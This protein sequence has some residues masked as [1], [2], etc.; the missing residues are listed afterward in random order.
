MDEIIVA[1]VNGRQ[2]GRLLSVGIVAH[3]PCITGWPVPLSCQPAI[4]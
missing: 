1:P 3:R 2:A 4:R